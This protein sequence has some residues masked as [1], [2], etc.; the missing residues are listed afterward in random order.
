MSRK[1]EFESTVNPCE[2]YAEWSSPEK[3]FVYY[4][5]EEKK[6]YSIKNGTKFLVLKETV[7]V[8]GW[9]DAASSGIYANEVEKTTE[10]PLKV[11]MFSGPVIAHG[12]Y[13]DIKDTIKAQGGKFTKNVYCMT[14]GGKLICIQIKGA[15]LGAWMDFT[16]KTRNRLADEWVQVSGT[17]DGKKGAIAFTMPEFAFVSSL[18]S[19]HDKQAEA[20][21]TELKSYFA[22]RS[23][24]TTEDV[25]EAPPEVMPVNTTAAGQEEVDFTDPEN[26]DLPF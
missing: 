22:S 8:R 15:A 1:Q 19:E 2:M 18:S 23:I 10:T 21:Y 26:D 14:E 12:L 25:D 17:V 6:N 4:N 11:K 13:A 9:N 7:T 24:Q 5:K 16:Q 3:S 20:M